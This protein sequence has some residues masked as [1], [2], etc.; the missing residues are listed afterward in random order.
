MDQHVQL[1][2]AFCTKIFKP[3]MP[4]FEKLARIWSV[5]AELEETVSLLLPQAKGTGNQL[6]IDYAQKVV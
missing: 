5:E 4:F 1:G 2:L 6:V 3:E